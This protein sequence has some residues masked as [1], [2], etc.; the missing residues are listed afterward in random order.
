MS[1]TQVDFKTLPEKTQE[2]VKKTMWKA[3]QTVSSGCLIITCKSAIYLAI[4]YAIFKW[5]NMGFPGLF[6]SFLR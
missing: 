6:D 4:A 2:N 1:T 3:S 5:A